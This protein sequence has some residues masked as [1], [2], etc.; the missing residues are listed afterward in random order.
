M[1]I[2]DSLQSIPSDLTN[3]WRCCTL[4]RLEVLKNF[5]Y[6]TFTIVPIE[7]IVSSQ[8]CVACT[9]FVRNCVL[10]FSKS[11]LNYYVIECLLL[12]SQSTLHVSN[13]LKLRYIA[14]AMLES[15]I[16]VSIYLLACKPVLKRLFEYSNIFEQGFQN[17]YLNTKTENRVFEKE[18]NRAPS[19]TRS[20]SNLNLSHACNWAQH[21]KN[22]EAATGNLWKVNVS[23]SV[24]VSWSLGNF[25]FSVVFLN[26]T[27][28]LGENSCTLCI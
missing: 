8:S 24:S 13:S 23:V 7:S 11:D 20:C 10:S 5:Y 25:I 19:P 1:S 22:S 4:K 2:E 14:Y 12:G 16:F 28:Q 26:T 6:W 18:L 27:C 9:T 21:D 15:P 17:E 3:R